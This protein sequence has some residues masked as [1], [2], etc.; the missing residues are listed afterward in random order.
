MIGPGGKLQNTNMKKVGGGT[1]I[2][3]S[4]FAQSG[5]GAT[6]TMK[7]SEQGKNIICVQKCF[8]IPFFSIPNPFYNQSKVSFLILGG[9]GNF[10]STQVTMI[11][12]SVVPIR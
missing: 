1:Y 10:P 6:T 3:P 4:A 9:H 2:S 8:L 5:V 7:L 12:P 11:I